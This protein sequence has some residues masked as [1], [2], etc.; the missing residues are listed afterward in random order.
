LS[1][2]SARLLIVHAISPAVEAFYTRCGFTRLPVEAPTYA[3]DL[4]KLER[5][6]SQE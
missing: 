6:A 4:A 3:L 2:I 1:G 5:L